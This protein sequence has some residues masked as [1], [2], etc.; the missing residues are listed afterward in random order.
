MTMT[1]CRLMVAGICLSAAVGCSS[2]PPVPPPPAAP[3]PAP[4][5]AAPLPASEV[6]PVYHEVWRAAENRAECRLLAPSSVDPASARPRAATF[7][8]GWG[9]AYDLPDQRSAFGVAGT[10]TTFTSDTYDEWPHRQ[11]WSDGSRVGYGPEGG[12]GAN[13]LAY[14]Q[15]AGEK[16]LYNVWSRRGVGHLE[17]LLGEL[18]FVEGVRG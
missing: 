7:G 9:V 13:Q 16:C 2:P 18:R 17:Q 6:A 11:V 10:G 15:V 12:S 14:L 4:W 3:P 8:G 5:S 1:G